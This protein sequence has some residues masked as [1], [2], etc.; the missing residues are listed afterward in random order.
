M[1]VKPSSTSLWH[2]FHL[3]LHTICRGTTLIACCIAAI[4]LFTGSAPVAMAIAVIPYIFTRM[5]EPR[6]AWPTAERPLDPSPS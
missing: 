4:V 2:D 3:A 5:F 1:L 6:S